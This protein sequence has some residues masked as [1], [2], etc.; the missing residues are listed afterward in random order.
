LTTLVCDGQEGDPVP[1]TTASLLGG[2]PCIGGVPGGRW[3]MMARMVGRHARF[4][5]CP[6]TEAGYETA[7]QWLRAAF[8]RWAELHGTDL[9]P[10]SFEELV[11][12][13]WGYLDGHLTRWTRADLDA[14]VLELF[15]AKM[16]V[17]DE[18]LAQVI[19]ETAAFIDFLTDTELLD[20][21][22]DDPGVLHAHLDGIEPRFRLH[23][24]DQSRYSPGKRFLSA[25]AAAGVQPDDE[26]AVAA[27]IEQFNTRPLAERDAVLGRR[28][29]TNAGTG[30]FTPPGTQPRPKPASRR[31]RHR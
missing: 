1:D 11:H 6:T 9:G 26:Q 7:R 12:Y 4:D 2:A 5:P 25:A 23:M 16:I 8:A 29:Q 17:D 24:A 27:F 19:P 13:K 20:P 31:R 21:A 10:D 14:V 28:T 30:R 22:S 15:P 18:D 3:A